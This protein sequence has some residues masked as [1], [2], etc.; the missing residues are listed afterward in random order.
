MSDG[1]GEKS[2]VSDGGKRNRGHPEMLKYD[3]NVMERGTKC[4]GSPTGFFSEIKNCS[5]GMTGGGV[6]L[7]FNDLCGVYPMFSQI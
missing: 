2:W 5:E 7:V 1:G 4:Y 6:P 3:R